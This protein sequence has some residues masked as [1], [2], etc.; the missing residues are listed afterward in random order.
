VTDLETFFFVVL[1]V[2][3]IGYLGAMFF[4]E[5]RSMEAGNPPLSE[6]EYQAMLVDRRQQMGLDIARAYADYTRRPDDYLPRLPQRL[7]YG[8]IDPFQVHAIPCQIQLLQVPE[9]DVDATEATQRAYDA[10]ELG[11][12]YIAYDVAFE[13]EGPNSGHDRA[14]AEQVLAERMG[15]RLHEALIGVLENPQPREHS[16][17]GRVNCTAPQCRTPNPTPTLTDARWEYQRAYQQRWA[18]PMPL[19]LTPEERAR[20]DEAG[21][22]L[23]EAHVDRQ[24]Q[25]LAAQQ[26]AETLLMEKLSI[27]QQRTWHE[28]GYVEVKGSK[29]GYTYKVHRYKSFNVECQ[30]ANAWYCAAPANSYE[31]PGEDVVLA[32]ILW[33][34]CDETGF[35]K[36]ANTRPIT[37]PLLGDLSFEAGVMHFP[38]GTYNL[39]D[40]GDMIEGRDI[41][42]VERLG[43]T[44]AEAWMPECCTT[45]RCHLTMARV[46][47][48]YAP[49]LHFRHREALVTDRSLE[50]HLVVPTMN[51][52][53]TSREIR[54]YLERNL[55]HRA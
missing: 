50:D 37:R 4:F 11:R 12:P 51:R 45:R 13:G 49:R 39:A 9:A 29:T 30:Q 5:R 41:G 40:L 24:K 18:P 17:C 7:D 21:R 1:L 16:S 35:L 10:V 2:A 14:V 8:R 26:R 46:E 25:R 20:Q 42:L 44:N 47:D 6:D 15:L 34:T 54:R 38:P 22:R 52:E 55:L 3:I 36:T 19:E 43:L 23:A 28:K 33:L 53:W 31:T 27:G 32:Q 48:P